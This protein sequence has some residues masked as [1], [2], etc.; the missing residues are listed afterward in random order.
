MFL[1]SNYGWCLIVRV[2][3]EL[4][5]KN[6]IQSHGLELF[7]FIDILFSAE[8]Q[9]GDLDILELDNSVELL[10]ICNEEIDKSC[11]IS[12]PLHRLASR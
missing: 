4:Q 9:V 6:L 5:L 2:A 10:V 12:P 1:Q 11:A 3:F 8:S 7:R